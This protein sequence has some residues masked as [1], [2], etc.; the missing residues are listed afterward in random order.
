[1][2]R[3]ATRLLAAAA[4]IPVMFV[5]GCSSDSG[6]Q[7]DGKASPAPGE[8]SAAPTVAPAKFSGLPKPCSVLGKDTIGDLVPKADSKSG[9]AGKSSDVEARGSCSWH[10]LDGFQYRWLDVSLQRFDS[11]ATLGDAESRAQE[12]FTKQ[13]SEAKSVKGG[14][15]VKDAGPSGIGDQAATVRYSVTKDGDGY[16]NQTVVTRTE[17]VVITLNYNGAG[18]EDAKP[19]KAEDLLKDAEKAAKEAVAAVAEANGGKGGAG[20]DAS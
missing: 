20:S 4:V 14:K 3:T 8:S 19:P 1:M 2:Y 5:A 17:N 6:D 10:G 9:T 7:A 12:Y 15:D 18:Y 11:D 13:V 16:R